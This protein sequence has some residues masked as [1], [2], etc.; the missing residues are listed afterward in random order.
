MIEIEIQPMLESHV[1][2]AARILSTTPLWVKSYGVTYAS[3]QRTLHAGLADTM[4][5]LCVALHDEQVV[6]L[7]YYGQRGAFYFGSYLRLLA[8]DATYR[9]KGVGG[10]LLSYVERQVQPVTS[11]LFLLATEHNVD[12]HRFYQRHGYMHVGAIP[13][14]V[15][16]G[17]TE[18]IFWKRLA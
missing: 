6:G 16:V 5:T 12:A 4:Q 14:F 15:A 9:G 10:Q 18:Y 7:V 8:V 2:I 17:I 1:D 13:D 3:A 11:S